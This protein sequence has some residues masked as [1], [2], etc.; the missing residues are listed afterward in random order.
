M[1]S[2]VL[3]IAL[4]LFASLSFALDI[5]VNRYSN[6]IQNGNVA[7]IDI[8]TNQIIEID[9]NG[10]VVWEYDIPFF[11]RLGGDMSRGADIEW[12]PTTD[13][14]LFVI[15]T[16]GIYEVNR[17]KEI[18]WSYKT[19]KVSH[20]A[21]ILPNNNI[22][23]INAWDSK[24][25][26]TYVEITRDGSLVE[27][28]TAGDLLKSIERYT[29]K[30][31]FPSYTHANSVRRLDDGSTLVSLRNF[32]KFVIVKNGDITYE[33][34][35]LRKVHD[36]VIVGDKICYALHR[37]D[38]LECDGELIFSRRGDKSWAPLRT[39]EK[40][41]NGNFLITGSTKIGQITP[42]GKLVWSVNLNEF[43]FQ[44]ARRK[45]KRFIYKAVWVYR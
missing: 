28:W 18:V 13:T 39:V 2:I 35:R 14:F 8:G 9:T 38:S 21:D 10:K 32:N 41:D 45:D 22:L 40:L 34:P 5:T 43:W 30:E 4:T 44:K 6:A 29:P 36:P 12:N 17:N 25:D 19:S 3:G 24:D 16:K 26:P 31:R 11:T 1:K 20:D 7:F 42:D 15:P 33:S 37:P 27:Q 23:F